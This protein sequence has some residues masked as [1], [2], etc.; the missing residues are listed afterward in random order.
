MKNSANW[1]DANCVAMNPQWW[2]GQFNKEMV[3]LKDV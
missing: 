1:I 3:I 2:L